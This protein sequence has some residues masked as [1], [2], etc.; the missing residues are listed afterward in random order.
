MATKRKAGDTDRRAL[1]RGRDMQAVSLEAIRRIAD[2]IPVTETAPTRGVPTLSALDARAFIER[3]DIDVLYEGEWNGGKKWVLRVCPFNAE[4]T[5]KSAVIIQMSDGRLGF[6][7]HHNGCNGKNWKALRALKEPEYAQRQNGVR[8]VK[9][10]PRAHQRVDLRTGEIIDEQTPPTEYVV[11]QRQGVTAAELYRTQFAPLFWT[12]E[13]ICPEGATLI[14]GKPKSRKSWAALAIAVACARGEKVFGRLQTRPGRVLYLDLESNQRRMRGRLFSMVGHQMRDMDNLHIYTE[15][16]RGD[17]G[18]AELEQWMG[19]HPDTVLIVIDV[20][21]DFRRAR[22]PKE[23]IYAYDRETVKPINEFA[24]RHR[25]TVLLIHHTRK[26]KADDVFDEISG[27]TGL[28]SAVATMWVLGRAPNGSGEMVLA[29]R[30]RD[31]IND[32]PLALEWDDYDNRFKITGGAADA[33]QGVERR[34]LLKILADDQEWGPKE[35]AIELHK[36]VNN[37]QQLL[38]ALLSEGLI[39]RTGRGKYV[40]VASRDQND[41][42]DQNSKITNDDHIVD[43][44]LLHQDQNQDQIRLGLQKALEGPSDRSDRDSKNGAEV[45][46]FAGIAPSDKVVLRNYL[47]SNIESDQERAQ[48]LCERYDID[49]QAA[50]KAVQREQ[51]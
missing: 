35:L 20:I 38:K 32:E 36:P 17:V 47:R 33:L 5:D 21:S 51:L 4:H 45:D 49:Y 18:L 48:V 46:I 1:L 29:L 3:H 14:A 24:E 10:T 30:G 8:P 2:H 34:A 40:R 50:Y 26:A 39:E 42:N 15:W 41:Q 44:D 7:C 13:N 27:S 25:I 6:R 12:V 11:K 31:L 9:D 19:D 16:S 28:P 37:V 23:D 22:D 43:S